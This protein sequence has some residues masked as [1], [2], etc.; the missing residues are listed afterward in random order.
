MYYYGCVA[1]MCFSVLINR[2]VLIIYKN[3]VMENFKCKLKN[4]LVIELNILNVNA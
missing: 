2:S 4:E 1:M 3:L